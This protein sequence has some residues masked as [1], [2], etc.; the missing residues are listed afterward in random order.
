MSMPQEWTEEVAESTTAERRLV[1]QHAVAS[2]LG[3]S[4]T[5]TDAT[6]KI[7]G[8]V[9]ESLDWDLGVIWRVD[10]EAGVLRCVATWH[11][12]GVE[13]LDDF[14]RTTRLTTFKLGEGV[15]GRVWT[16]KDPVWI[17]NVLEEPTFIRAAL[18]AKHGIH[19][20]F[21][22]PIFDGDRVFGVMQ[23][24][25]Q[26]TREP[27]EALLQM[28]AT[29]GMQLGQFMRQKRT[30]EHLQRAEEL[31]RV[32]V[33]N[34]Q[35]LISITDAEG[36]LLYASPSHEKVIGYTPAELVGRSALEIIHPEDVET[37]A[38][39]IREGF[40][41]GRVF[42]S[43]LRVSH[44]DGRWITVEGVGTAIRDEQGNP[45]ML[46]ANMRDVTDRKRA[47]EEIAYLAYHDKLTGLPNRAM[48]EE[49]AEMA[50]V[51]ARRQDFAV[52]VLY[53]DLDNFKMVNDSLG[54]AAGDELLK[55][56]AERLKEVSRASDVVTRLAGDEFLLLLT[57]LQRDID[58]SIVG[59]DNAA[60]IA[61][62]V[63]TRAHEALAERFVLGDSEFYLSASIGISIFP[64]DA[65]DAR[66]LVRNADAAMY[67]SK[68]AGPGG[69]TLYPLDSREH[70]SKLSIV[71][72][73]RQS[74]E[75]QRFIL[76]YQP[77]V[78]LV[79]R[80]MVGVEALLRWDDPEDGLV[81]PGDFIPIAEEMGLIG[82]IG[83]WVVEEL[84]RQWR[85]WRDKGMEFIVSFNL[86]PRQ[87]W[88]PGLVE[89]LLE[90]LDVWRMDPTSVLVEITESTAMTDPDRTQQI[91]GGLRDRGIRIAIDDFGTG[92]SSLSRLK[93]LAVDVLKV[94]RSFVH[95]VPR[96][97][98]AAT[99]VKGIVQL[100]H[101]L[102]MAP[103]AEGVE[104]EEQCRFLVGHGCLLGQGHYFSPPAPPEEMDE[105][106]RTSFRHAARPK[107]WP[108]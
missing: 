93:D 105:M 87:L 83:D 70:S 62:T 11:D 33:E 91:L 102:N 85:V 36:R 88:H 5:L 39:A 79:R 49:L 68:N 10:E 78:D 89:K 60:L 73:L 71:T 6:P 38:E 69:Y 99:M 14:D 37:A 29:V 56:V 9:C 12:P 101:S 7:L 16:S 8:A 52:A 15:P 25:S 3:S 28:L 67:R 98:E 2:A 59:A 55:Q 24:Y 41:E 13:T 95:D 47:E 27:D 30:Q 86:S 81:Q 42:R 100:A 1:A 18:A 58:G 74:V 50:I 34:T 54:H 63:A 17:P 92:Y 20:S 45:V 64:L 82:P 22:C 108:L 80:D 35:D 97:R 90:R 26:E 106:W 72:R 84:F 77:I 4:E 94:D 53:I 107:S 23:F 65:E 75:E 40:L 44:K 103:L 66:T 31:Y 43:E 96:D 57:D 21:A 19:A 46:Q 76:H 32:V 48:F 104:N 61:E 51:R